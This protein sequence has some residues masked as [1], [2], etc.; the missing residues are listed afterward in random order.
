MASI[1]VAGVVRT[2]ARWVGWNRCRLG[3]RRRDARR[4][5]LNANSLMGSGL[6]H[7]GGTCR[8]CMDPG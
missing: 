8:V 3:T 2:D 1:A 6:D 5:G 4:N 7:G